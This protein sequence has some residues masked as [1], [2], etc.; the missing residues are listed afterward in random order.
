[1]VIS[2]DMDEDKCLVIAYAPKGMD[3]AI[4]CKAWVMA[5]IEGTDG[6][7]GGKED[8]ANFQVPGA[9]HADPMM[10]KALQYL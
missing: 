7:G 3:P 4:D 2:V 10:Q 6:K 1:M 5:T 9:A 8:S